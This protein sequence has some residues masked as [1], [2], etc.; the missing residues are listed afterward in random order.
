MNK[1][2]W[3]IVMMISGM[4]LLTACSPSPTPK[5]SPAPSAA[6]TP[7]KILAF[8]DSLTSGKD[9][10]NPDQDS[11]P[12]QLE[13]ALNTKNHPVAVINAGVSG[14]TTFD[15]LARIDFSLADKPALVI[16]ALGSNDTFQGKS[17]ADIERNLDGLCTKI[18]AAGARG[19]LAGFKTFPNLGPFYAG[20]YEDLFPRVAKKHKMWLIPFFLEGVANKP[21]MNLGDG[22]HPNE[23]GYARVVE[24]ILPVIEKALKDIQK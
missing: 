16:L 2:W 24:T 9:L 23:K 17:L 13:R 3:R 14:D 15:G 11:Y 12:A 1:V 20:A 8:G 4:G 7:L 22:I 21:D 10:A 5:S 18:T 6:G 19:I